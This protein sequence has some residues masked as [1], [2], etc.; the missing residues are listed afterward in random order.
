MEQ[1]YLNMSI[2]YSAP[3]QIYVKLLDKHKFMESWTGKKIYGI[4]DR[5]NIYGFLHRHKIYGILG[6]A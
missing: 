1:N 3:F 6:Q 5:Q 2:D 4:V